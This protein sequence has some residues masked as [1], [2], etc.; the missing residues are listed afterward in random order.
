MLKQVVLIPVFLY[1][2]GDSTMALRY[3]L[4][5]SWYGKWY[6]DAENNWEVLGSTMVLLSNQA[7]SNFYW[8]ANSEKINS[9]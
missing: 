9:I 5:G 1:L 8:C 2:A 6:E 4:S 3:S 7:C